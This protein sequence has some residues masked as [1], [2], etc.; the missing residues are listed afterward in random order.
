[1]YAAFSREHNIFRE[2]IRSFV[3]KEVPYSLAREIDRDCLYPH[4][5]MKKLAESGFMGVN[6]PKQ[7]GGEGKGLFEIMI[8]CEEIGKRCPALSWAWGNVSLYGN[9]IIGI[10]GNEAQRNEFLPRLVKGEILFAFGLTEPNA[11][12]D[13]ANIKTAAEFKDG[14]WIINGSKMF[15]TGGM[16]S[17]VIVTLTRTAKS[18]YGGIT[19]FLVDS[20]KEGFSRHTIHKLGFRG[21]DTAELVYENVQVAPSDILGGEE[22]LNKGW[23]QMVSL[24]NG[25]R[26]TLS[27]GA[28]GIADA[29][30]SESIQYFKSFGPAHIAGSEQSIK[31]R[32]AEMATELEAANCLAY[33]AATLQTNGIDCVKETSMAKIFCVETARK[34]ALLAMEIM[35][36]DGYMMDS[37]VQRNLR[38]VLILAIGGGTTQIQ[39]NIVT[40]TIGL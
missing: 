38:D 6:V 40:K 37:G 31:H 30:L 24:L 23:G 10:N 25:E 27:A 33:N 28:L 29:A 7:Y 26:L 36:P 5:L 34:I 8:I 39:K 22:C 19:T 13:S 16:M 20:S 15:I 12:S 3:E 11:G 17:D 14:A 2:R 18:R 9:N 4:N 21:S 1:M 35:G 32:F